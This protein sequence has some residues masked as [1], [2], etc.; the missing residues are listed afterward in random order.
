MEKKPG[1]CGFFNIEDDWEKEWK[2]MP[3][4]VQEDKTSVKSIHVHFASY[5]DMEEFAKLIGQVISKK[6]RSIWFPKAD[7][8]HIADKRYVDES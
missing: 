6:T 1:L 4:F 2:G 7:I 8:G 5:E 3:E